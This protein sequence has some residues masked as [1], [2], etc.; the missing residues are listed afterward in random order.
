MSR[1]LIDENGTEIVYRTTIEEHR[2]V[3]CPLCDSPHIASE[4]IG[5]G[6]E[7]RCRNCGALIR[8]VEDKEKQNVEKDQSA[9]CG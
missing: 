5:I 6:S 2:V 7:A 9:S 8:I 3:I 1:A 4:Q